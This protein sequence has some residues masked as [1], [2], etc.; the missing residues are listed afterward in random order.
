MDAQ[1][2]QET[3]VSIVELTFDRTE[4]NAVL[5]FLVKD[6]HP[7]QMGVS[8]H[9]YLVHFRSR[10]ERMAFATGFQVAFD[11]LWEEP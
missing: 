6:S 7:D 10:A 8:L 9:G 3:P 1:L 11:I 5:A 2:I 4:L